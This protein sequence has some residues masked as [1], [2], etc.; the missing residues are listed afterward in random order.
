[1]PDATEL[2]AKILEIIASYANVEPQS[3]AD[4]KTLQD[5]PI[6]SVGML[7]AFDEIEEE[8]D[9]KLGE[10]ITPETTVD[11]FVEL[12]QAIIAAKHA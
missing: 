9:I 8:Y 5:L 10:G 7:G 3:M 2:R 4:A 11:Q 6:D 1:M 12:L